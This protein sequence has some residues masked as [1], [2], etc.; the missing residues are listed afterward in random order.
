MAPNR[1]VSIAATVVAAMTT[2]ALAG[3]ISGSDPSVMATVT[4]AL[5]AGQSGD[6]RTLRDQYAPGCVFI[7]EFAPFL[8]DGPNAIDGYFASGARMYRETQHQDGKT[9]IKPPSFIYVSGDRAFVVEPLSGT[10]TVRGAPYV[11]QGSFAFTLARA[12][13]RW[14]ITSQTW[15]KANESGNPYAP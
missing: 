15:T 2:P 8:W 1:L 11:Q 13:G 6:I 5:D 10:A 3:Q 7:D 14:R 4:A 12:E 9:T